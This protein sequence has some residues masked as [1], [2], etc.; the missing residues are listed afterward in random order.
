MDWKEIL[1]VSVII[2]V[3]TLIA[4]YVT[5]EFIGKGAVDFFNNLILIGGV[6][7]TGFILSQ[8]LNK[9]EGW[10][11]P[12]GMLITFLIPYVVYIFL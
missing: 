6:V 5:I 8:R 2:G 11:I 1:K 4:Y 12:L 9:K 7:A 3:V 10:G